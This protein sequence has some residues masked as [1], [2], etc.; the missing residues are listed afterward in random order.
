MDSESSI[1]PSTRVPRFPYFCFCAIGAFLQLF[2]AHPHPDPCA[3]TTSARGSHDSAGPSAYFPSCKYLRGQTCA[4]SETWPKTRLPARCPS[5]AHPSSA[6]QPVAPL[7]GAEPWRSSRCRRSA[8]VPLPV[9]RSSPPFA[10][11]DIPAFH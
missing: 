11:L 5:T 6:L 3:A 7:A 4:A 2:P 8:P 9:F 1:C 10:P